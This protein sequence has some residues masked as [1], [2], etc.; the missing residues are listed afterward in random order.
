MDLKVCDE[1]DVS[2]LN[3]QCTEKDKDKDTD[4]DKDKDK[5]R[6]RKGKVQ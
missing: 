4:K 2:F 1:H 5:D 6:I 3:S